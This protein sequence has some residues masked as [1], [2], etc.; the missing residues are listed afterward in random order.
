MYVNEIR[1]DTRDENLHK[2][3]KKMSDDYIYYIGFLPKIEYYDFIELKDCIYSY[4]DNIF[5][6]KVISTKLD[7]ENENIKCK[8]NELKERFA[9]RLYFDYNKDSIPKPDI[10]L[11]IIHNSF[12]QKGEQ[13]MFKAIATL[14]QPGVERGQGIHLFG[15]AGSGKTTL[16]EIFT[17]L[18]GANR[19]GR[20]TSQKS[21]AFDTTFLK[22]ENK[23]NIFDEFSPNV[24]LRSLI[25][26]VTGGEYFT[27]NAKYKDMQM[28]QSE[29]KTVVL[30]NPEMDFNMC[31]K[32]KSIVD[33]QKAA[34]DRFAIW[35]QMK[36]LKNQVG[37]AKKKIKNEIPAILILCNEAYFEKKAEWHHVN[38]IDENTI[39]Q[40]LEK[41]DKKKKA[42]KKR[43]HEKLE[44]E[45]FESDKEEDI[46]NV[47]KKRIE[48]AEEKNNSLLNENE[49]HIEI[50]KEVNDN[51]NQ[52]IEEQGGILNE[53]KIND[54]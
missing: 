12:D 21:G 39:M 24:N 1:D 18:F 25:L 54:I 28:L 36:E 8:F 49:T 43:K 9:C 16:F 32:D 14:L 50:E 22:K 41:T 20:I 44:E 48:I 5:C 29:V 26:Q 7:L 4:K 13:E 46:A 3:H 17:Y 35:H 15:S 47:K 2:H 42:S 45:E 52:S 33:I 10:F 51:V 37:N 38:P 34:R 30:S 40:R 19:V 6:K 53:K 27:R 23:I 31:N 11:Q